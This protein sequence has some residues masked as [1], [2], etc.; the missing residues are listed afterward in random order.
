MWR[1][2]SLDAEARA[3]ACIGDG[4][5]LRLCRCVAKVKTMSYQGH[6]SNKNE[7]SRPDGLFDEAA[8]KRSKAQCTKR[9]EERY[10]REGRRE[11]MLRSSGSVPVGSTTGAR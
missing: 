10:G 8:E 6:G 1:L 4:Q 7:T 9:R 11:L 3:Q 5:K 2:A